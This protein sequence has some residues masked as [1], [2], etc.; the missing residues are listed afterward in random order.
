MLAVLFAY[1]FV[2]RRGWARPLQESGI[3]VLAMLGVLPWFEIA[4]AL[5]NLR[6]AKTRVDERSTRDFGCC[7]V[8]SLAE[9]CRGNT[10]I[11]TEIAKGRRRAEMQFCVATRLNKVVGGFDARARARLA[12]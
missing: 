7:A 11:A 2:W 3:A 1:Y 10:E 4:S 8:A 6:N 5:L 9:P 12:K